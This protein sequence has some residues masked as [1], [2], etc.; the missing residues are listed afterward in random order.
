[1]YDR[2]MRNFAIVS[3]LLFVLI[4]FGVIFFASGKEKIYVSLDSYAKTIEENDIVL[5]KKEPLSIKIDEL[6]ECN[7]LIP[8]LV[9]VSMEDILV[10][11]D[12]Q[13]NKVYITIN[14][15]PGDYY[16][17]NFITAEEGYIAECFCE[18]REEDTIVEIS[19]NDM[20]DSQIVYKNGALQISFFKPNEF[21]NKV[22]LLNI[23]N[24]SENRENI[25]LDVAFRTQS[26]FSNSD[27]KVYLLRTRDEELTNEERIE[28]VRQLQPDL[29]V[30]LN[31]SEEESGAKEG[32]VTYYNENYFI[33]F[34]GNEQLADYIEYYTLKETQA[35]VLGISPLVD[36]N[37]FL[38]EMIMPAAQINIGYYSNIDE[39][40]LM[41]DEEY[42]N[43]IALGIY[44]GLLKSCENLDAIEER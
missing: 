9:E 35:V 10:E 7:L 23:P 8:L 39:R 15:N 28:F 44:S 2:V 22:I 27:T 32:I 17:T 16:E 33:P 14:G 34:F 1:M 13:K 40:I 24:T 4:I 43:K 41:N 26:L 29:V 42:V 30:S 20:Y 19:L 21:Y 25:L 18:Y 36:E 5:Q 38:T 37:D 3:T 31:F 12:Y 11:N 6:D